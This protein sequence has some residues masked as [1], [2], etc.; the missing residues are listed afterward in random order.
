MSSA[1]WVDAAAAAE[2]LGMTKRWVLAQARHDR[3]PHVRPS[4]NRVRFE[5]GELDRWMLARMRGPQTK[6]GGP[7]A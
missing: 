3:I 4:P 2:H 5:L 7:V 1:R 6:P